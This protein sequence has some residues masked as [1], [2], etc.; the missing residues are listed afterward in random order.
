V[1]LLL[2]VILRLQKSNNLT[3]GLDVYEA[4]VVKLVRELDRSKSVV[5][6]FK[7]ANDRLRLDFIKFLAF[8]Q[9][10][11]DGRSDRNKDVNRIVFGY[12]I[13]RERAETYLRNE[14]LSHKPRS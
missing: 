7:I 2:G 6:D 8:E 4:I 14:R 9:L 1:P 5:R 12:D 3:G 11:K 10:L 13:L